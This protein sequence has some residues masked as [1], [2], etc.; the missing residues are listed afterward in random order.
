MQTAQAAAV[1]AVDRAHPALFLRPSLP[2][3]LYSCQRPARYDPRSPKANPR[4]A[5]GKA[6]F[7]SARVCPLGHRGLVLNT[8]CPKSKFARH[9]SQL[10]CSPRLGEEQ[11][12]EGAGQTDRQAGRQTFQFW[13]FGVDRPTDKEARATATGMLTGCQGYNFGIHELLCAHTHRKEPETEK[14]RYNRYTSKRGHNYL[15]GS[16]WPTTLLNVRMFQQPTMCPT[17]TSTLNHSVQA[18]LHLP[19]RTPT[20]LHRSSPPSNGS[21]RRFRGSHDALRKLGCLGFRV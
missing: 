7:A 9:L 16:H 10:H 5:N 14:K 13:G 17:H 3:A 6:R 21:H 4:R 11:R 1:S 19:A 12:R 20:R 2:L 8:R 15:D 18:A